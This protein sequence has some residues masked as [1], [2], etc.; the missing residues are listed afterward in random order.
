M[1]IPLNLLYSAFFKISKGEFLLIGSD[2]LQKKLWRATWW[3]KRDYAMQQDSPKK[4]LWPCH[5][6]GETQ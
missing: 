1:C 2:F 4:Q 3:V 6:A 5:L